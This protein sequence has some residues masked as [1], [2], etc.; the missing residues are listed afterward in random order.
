MVINIQPVRL[1]ANRVNFS[2]ELFE[3]PWCQFISCPVGAV[4][5]YFNAVKRRRDSG[6]QELQIFKL[7][8]CIDCNAAQTVSNRT[9]KLI[10]FLIHQ[11]F[12]LQFSLVRQFIPVAAKKFNPIILNWIV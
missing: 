1:R 11:L 12:D 9:R 3:Q 6:L 10:H 4:K 7:G 5:H 8:F 2:S